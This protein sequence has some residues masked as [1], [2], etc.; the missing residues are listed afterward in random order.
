MRLPAHLNDIPQDY[1]PDATLAAFLSPAV[2]AVFNQEFWATNDIHEFME[3]HALK[4]TWDALRNE[5]WRRIQAESD[6]AA[7]RDGTL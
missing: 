2:A 1:P 5:I 3:N 4:K 6:R 7:F